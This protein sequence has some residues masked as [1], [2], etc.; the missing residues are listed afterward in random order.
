MQTRKT[1]F[2]RIVAAAGGLFAAY[3][4]LLCI[5]QPFFAFS[6][7]AGNLVLRSDREFSEGAGKQV[8]ELAARKLA[9]SPLYSGRQSHSVFICNSRWRQMLFF[10]KDFG[11]GGVAQY[12]ATPNVFLRDARIE[13]NCLISARGTPVTGDR[14]LDYYVAHEITHQLTGQA[15]GPLRFYRLPQWVREG[16]ADYVGKGI[17]FDYNAAR[18]A[19]LAK[20]PEMDF[21]RSGLYGRFHLLVAYLLDH[22]HWSVEQLLNNPPLEAGVE[23]AI[24]EEK[25]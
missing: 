7:R 9:R 14:T 25:P 6:V 11:V 10:N 13:D 15:I 8:L 5:P 16:Y 18:R 21:K 20:T 1:V 3:A 4:V 22:Q 19:F 17:S 2:V 23:A 24:R 12:P